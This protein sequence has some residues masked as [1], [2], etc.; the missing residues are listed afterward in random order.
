MDAHPFVWFV[1]GSM[2]LFAVVL[3]WA[4]WVTRRG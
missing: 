1:I 2:S 3:G 4:T